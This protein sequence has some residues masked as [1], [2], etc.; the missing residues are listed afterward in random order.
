MTI[1]ISGGGID[2][3]GPV[4]FD[5]LQPSQVGGAYG[6]GQGQLCPKET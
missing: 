5:S 6:I 3:I 1:L 2:V 4:T